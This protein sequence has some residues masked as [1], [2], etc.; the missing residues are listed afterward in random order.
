MVSEQFLTQTAKD[1]DLEVE[2]VKNLTQNCK[3]SE[4][5]EILESYIKTS[6]YIKC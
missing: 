6:G 5:Y 4:F 1:Y 3:N 2:I